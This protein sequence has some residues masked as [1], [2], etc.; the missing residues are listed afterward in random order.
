MYD[1]IFDTEESRAVLGRVVAHYA[2][3]FLPSEEKDRAYYGALKKEEAARSAG[4]LL[5]HDGE[6]HSHAVSWVEGSRSQE[7][8][9]ERKSRR[10]VSLRAF[11]DELVER[12]NRLREGMDFGGVHAVVEEAAEAVGKDRSRGVR[13]FKPSDLLRYDAA[14]FLAWHLGGAPEGVWLHSG[15][16][17]GYRLLGG[18]RKKLTSLD[19]LPEPFRGLPAWQVEDILCLYKDVFRRVRSRKPVGDAAFEKIAATRQRMGCGHR[20][21]SSC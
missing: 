15:A 7:G 12:R 6:R 14:L 13:T 11:S 4:L 19:E 17:W 3:T 18:L 10:E 5:R 21:C 16:D 2:G 9:E 1:P 20:R 8:G